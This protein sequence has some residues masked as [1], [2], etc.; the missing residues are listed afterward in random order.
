ML[1]CFGWFVSACY[2]IELF[3]EITER[4]IAAK[5]REMATRSIRENRGI[6]LEEDSEGWVIIN[7]TNVPHYTPPHRGLS[8]C[9]C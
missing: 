9:R 7:N 4:L 5:D 3:G 1:V 6:H 8:K 2:Y